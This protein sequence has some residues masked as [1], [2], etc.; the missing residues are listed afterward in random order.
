[1]RALILTTAIDIAHTSGAADIDYDL[2]AA[3][4]GV[5]AEW[6]EW[7]FPDLDVLRALAAEP[8]PAY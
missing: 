7:L 8:Q 6:V 3:L 2:V 1:M 5:K 4:A